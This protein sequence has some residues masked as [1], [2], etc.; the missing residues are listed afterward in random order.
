MRHAIYLMAVLLC[1][2][3]PAKKSFY[4]FYVML[5]AHSDR[6]GVVGIGT[7]E[8]VAMM[9]NGTDTLKQA[10][11]NRELVFKDLE[12]G[13]HWTIIVDCPGYPRATKEVT[14]LKEPIYDQFILKNGHPIEINW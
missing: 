1:L 4:R 9:T 6:S 10:V 2:A 14:I 13:S 3:A 7:T 12:I 8:G 5:E 11:T